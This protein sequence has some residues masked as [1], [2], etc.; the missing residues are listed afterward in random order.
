MNI[1]LLLL[2]KQKTKILKQRKAVLPE[3]SETLNAL[4][5]GFW[6]VCWFSHFKLNG[7]YF[8]FHIVYLCLKYFKIKIMRYILILSFYNIYIFLILYRNSCCNLKYFKDT[9]AFPSYEAEMFI[10]KSIL[11]NVT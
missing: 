7:I 6:L 11:L 8:F 2:R 5:M 1:T 3:F 10:L 9:N 4:S